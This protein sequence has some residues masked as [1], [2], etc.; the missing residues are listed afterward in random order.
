M[1]FQV[2]PED[3]TMY[4]HIDVC[5]EETRKILNK[6]IHFEYEWSDLK[7]IN[8]DEFGFYPKAKDIFGVTESGKI[9]QI[10]SKKY[11]KN[12]TD[13]AS[14]ASKKASKRWK[15]DYKDILKGNKTIPCFKE[16]DI[17]LHNRSIRKITKDNNKHFIRISLFSKKYCQDNN[18]N[19]GMVTFNLKVSDNTQRVIINR[20]LN[21]EYSCAESQIKYD[22]NKKKFFLLLSYK[23]ENEET[24]ERTNVMGIDLGIKYPAYV[25]ICDSKKRMSIKG[26]EIEAFRSQVEKRRRELRKQR[27]YCGDASKGRGRKRF[28]KPVTKIG[29]KVSSFRNLV[30]HKYSKHIVEFAVKNDC[31]E[32]RMENLSGINKDEIFLKNWSYYDLQTK[33]ENKANEFGISVVYVDPSYTSQTCSN[34]GHVNKDNR[35]TQEEFLCLSCELK[36]NADYN[37]ACNIA[38]PAFGELGEV[39]E[40]RKKKNGRADLAA[41][42]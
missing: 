39:V 22:K 8:K 28:L 14:S 2:W 16:L 15:N 25:A 12:N 40:A 34:C 10:I 31:Y 26:G 19:N 36:E 37:A 17:I 32:V 30:N 6:T 33:I 1:K 42:K 23:F 29:D 18:L 41:L 13:N 3:K 35:K 27:N 38:N 5:M 7:L 4:K 20:I 21:G 11:D 24:K 9:Y